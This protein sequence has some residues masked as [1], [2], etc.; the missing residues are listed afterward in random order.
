MDSRDYGKEFEQLNITLEEAVLI[1]Q[2]Q[3]SGDNDNRACTEIV[4]LS[5]AL[6]RITAEDCV[7]PINQPP[8]A[9]S[10]LD[11]YALIAADTRGAGKEKPAE[12]AVVGEVLA[13]DFWDGQLSRGQAV[14]V[15]TGAPIP[16]GADC[17]IRQEDTDYG[18][19]RVA[20]FRELSAYENYCY[21]GEDFAV[22]DCLIAAGVRITAV[23]LGILASMGFGAVKVRSM[24]KIALLATGD[25]L[26]QPGE[27]LRPGA[28]YNANQFLLRGRLTELGVQPF[29]T[30]HLPD[31]EEL[32]AQRLAELARKADL[33]LTTGGVSVGKRDIMHGALAHAGA[34]KIFWRIQIKPG[35]PVIFA[36]LGETPVLSLSGNPYGALAHLEVLV[37]PL[38]AHMTGC[39]K[40]CAGRE[41]AVIGQAFGKGSGVRRL[42]R[43]KVSNG[44]V[45][46]P[47]GH[48]SGMLASMQ[49]CN[50][51]VDI[52]AG[53][54]P[55]RAGD[56]VEIIRL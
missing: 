27:A 2:Q 8:F 34:R 36:Q 32:V 50:C 23:E 55:L 48:S 22:G 19:D 3:V 52:P 15:M 33:I 39:G 35:M 29:V 20:V 1:L 6:G 10:P 4:P 41:T 30:E 13:G 45:C 24:P 49:G 43:A 5:E 53:S 18:M 47:D 37:R 40:L 17:V 56:T 26:V 12:L 51:L 16:A 38:L 11:G 28:I 21:A 9:R 44:R 25:E 7:S 54:S 31:R 42:V 14:R 46:L